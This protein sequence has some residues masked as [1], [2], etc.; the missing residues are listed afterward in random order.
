MCRNPYEAC[1]PGEKFPG[2][3]C[4]PVWG[5]CGHAFH[6]QCVMKWL[7]SQ[8]NVKQECPLCRQAWGFREE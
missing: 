3:D 2:D 8:Q 7:E 4:P 5:K 6:M 1:C